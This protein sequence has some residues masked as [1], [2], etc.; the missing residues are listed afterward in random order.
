M[1]QVLGQGENH[2]GKDTGVVKASN[3]VNYGYGVILDTAPNIVVQAGSAGIVVLGVAIEDGA[4]NNAMT[5]CYQGDVF[6]IANAA[7][8][9][10]AEIAVAATGK[11]A[12]ATTGQRVV[13]FAKTA[14]AADGDTFLLHLYDGGP[15]S[16]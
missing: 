11:F 8:S 5:Y 6:A 12:T 14:A 9:A 10:K 16:P 3:S 13:G 1:A 4:E 15:V 2:V 7:I